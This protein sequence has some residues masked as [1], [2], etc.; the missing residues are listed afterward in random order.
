MPPRPF[1]SYDSD[2]NWEREQRLERSFSREPSLNR[3]APR[4]TADDT[5][6]AMLLRAGLAFVSCDESVTGEGES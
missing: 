3:P 1:D 4:R 2:R 6:E 5:T